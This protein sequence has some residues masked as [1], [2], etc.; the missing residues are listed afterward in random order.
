M[1]LLEQLNKQQREAV[2]VVDQHVRI[3]AGA[4]SGKTKVVTTRIAYLI[5]EK[6]VYPNH[7]LAIT[8]TNK[9]AKE[10]KE[11]VE[12]ILHDMALAVRIST[13]HS[14][15]VRL[16]RE[17]IM[18]LGYPRNFTIL[19][20]DDQKS[21]LKDIYKKLKIQMKD[22]SYGAVLGYI[23]ANK[24]N[25]IDPIMAINSARN[26]K[27]DQIKAE[28]YRLY[29]ERLQEMY[30]LDFDDLLIFAYHVLH[31]YK[32]VREKWQRR[33]RYIHVDEFQDVDM[34]QYSI[35]RLLTGE[36]CYLC[37]VGDPDQTIYT[38]R[39]AQVDIIMNFEKD[40]PNSKTVILNRNYRSTQMILT[41]ANTLIKNNRNRVDKDLYTESNDGC[42]IV[43]FHAT[44]ESSEPL[45]VAGRIQDLHR[46]GI[47]YRDIAVLYRSN[48]LSKSLEKTF[49][50]M[51]IPY[52]IY[53]GIRF[54]DRQE[55]KDAL[56][57]LRLLEKK[58]NEQDKELY[59]DLAIK[60]VI[61]S[62]KRGIGEKTMATIEAQAQVDGT[63]MYEVIK[64][65]QVGKGK[66][67]A[68][69]EAFVTLI[70]DYRAKTETMALDQLLMHLLE[71]SGYLEVLR[72]NKEEERLENIKELVSDIAEYI[73]NNPQATLEE[74]LQDI[75]L[76]T[77]ND[78]QQEA[79]YVQLMTIHAAKGLEF[80][81]VFVYN[82]CE[83][84]FPN[85]KSVIEGGTPALEEERRL[86][87]VAFTRAKKQLFLSDSYGYSFVLDKIKTTSRFI[88]ELPEE[89][90]EEVGAKQSSMR[91]TS[92]YSGQEFLSSYGRLEKRTEPLHATVKTPVKED[93]PKKKG[94]IR[95]GD[96]VTHKAFGDG[97]VISLD[98]TLATIAFEQKFGIRKIDINHASL[99]KK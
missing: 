46:Q 95:K 75:S 15:C 70:E 88:K 31:D 85:E 53:G 23:S 35:I 89:C 26:F 67:K 24:T 71:D 54:Y 27:D 19:D 32:E 16:L 68:N 48:Y 93:K 84:V 66:A 58:R 3:I 80:D 98:G 11:R 55:V 28:I 36:H 38:W 42:N 96:L 34:L 10:M 91:S 30:A 65:Y 76:F 41:A 81:N 2:E 7:I 33:F 47:A 20:A 62:P 21:I 40:F 50:P 82:L 86:A 18:Q 60:R 49:V 94:R 99:S 90:M 97:V 83:G 59:K 14:F 4:G 56:S 17:D 13:I 45:W 29:Q 52:R 57:Y 69:I 73:E 25:F 22:L 92:S 51:H 5:Q 78:V 74:Y 64:N 43:H 37:V 6:Q 44:D 9:A 12:N 39:G 87:Y 61:N 8:F 77:D 79:D 63:N 1:S 72:E